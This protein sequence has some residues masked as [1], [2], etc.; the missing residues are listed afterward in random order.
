MNDDELRR[1]YAAYR[2]A[3]AA[4]GDQVAERPSLE[5]MQRLIE[6]ELGEDDREALLDRVLANP[7]TTRELAMLQAVS[8]PV[9][10]KAR[11]RATPVWAMA[12]AAVLAVA[13]VPTLW[14]SRG[15]EQEPVFRSAE[16]QGTIRIVAPAEGVSLAPGLRITWRSTPDADGYVVELVSERGDAV[17]KI[18]SRDTTL[19]L[20]DSISAERLRMTRG[21][22]VVARLRDGGQRQSLLKLVP[23]AP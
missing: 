5:E 22:M 2:S 20:P 12:A 6:G 3:P 14:R 13:L 21:M 23:K 15:V 1:A 10:A 11:W 8:Q 16:E 18:N 17:A 19:V 7:E 4:S 9:V